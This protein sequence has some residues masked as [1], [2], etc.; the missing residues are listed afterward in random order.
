VPRDREGSFEPR[1]IAKG[2]TRL[3]GLDDKIIALYARGM[4]AACA[5]HARGMS[6]RDI[7]GHLEEAC[8]G[9]RRSR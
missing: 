3:D 1:L 4:R 7:R 5:R 9:P 6:V 2:Q 8:R